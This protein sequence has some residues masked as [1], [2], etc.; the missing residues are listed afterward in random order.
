[1]AKSVTHDLD[2]AHAE[3]GR[4]SGALVARARTDLE[5]QVLSGADYEA[6]VSGSSGM[7]PTEA[8]A[9]T[10]DRAGEYQRVVKTLQKASAILY[11]AWAEL[12][13]T[14]TGEDCPTYATDRDG[15]IVRCGG[16]Q[17]HRG[18]C[19][20]CHRHRRRNQPP[21]DAQLLSE[22]NSR[23]T[24][25]CPCG[26]GSCDHPA[27]RCLGRVLPGEGPHCDRC[28]TVRQRPTC[29]DCGDNPPAPERTICNRCR[30]AQRP[31]RRKDDDHPG[32]WQ[33]AQ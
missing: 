20:N 29:T 23:M 18:L 4:L 12:N 28:Q 31:E 16:Q 21:P 11:D 14:A 17:T 6:R 27:G 1:M 19:H 8:G 9:M 25:D 24:R 15:D 32:Q 5:G 7:T 26:W 22:W 10:L 30:S 2:R 33:D 3:I 13:P